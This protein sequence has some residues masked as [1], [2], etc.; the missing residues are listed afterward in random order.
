MTTTHMRLAFLLL[1]CGVL[2]WHWAYFVRK[3]F[4]DE[5]FSRADDVRIYSFFLATFMYTMIAN[6][7]LAIACPVT[8]TVSKPAV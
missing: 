6:A 4:A 5:V 2:A 3:R 7:L 8:Q 1:G